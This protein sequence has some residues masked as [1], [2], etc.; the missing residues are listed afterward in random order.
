MNV[1]QVFYPFFAALF[2]NS[3]NY[4]VFA[5]VLIDKYICRFYGIAHVELKY[6]V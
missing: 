3:A 2:I 5:E 1:L 4:F 6:T